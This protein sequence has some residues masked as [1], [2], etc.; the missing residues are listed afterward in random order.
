ML[1]GFVVCVVVAA[2]L[3]V[4][5]YYAGRAWQR[6]QQDRAGETPSVNVA[7]SVHDR[8]TAQ[9]KEVVAALDRF[10]KAY[11]ESRD[12][13]SGVRIKWWRIGALLADGD[14]VA[15][16]IVGPESTRPYDWAEEVK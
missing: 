14:R 1:L 15:D 10:G 8:A 12:W 13:L 5:T 3:G 6:W 7:I 4:A 2:L 9:I 16:R 11:T